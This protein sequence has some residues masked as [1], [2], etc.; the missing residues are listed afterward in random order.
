MVAF[1]EEHEAFRKTV[2]T[3]VERE[4]DPYVDEWERDGTIPTHELF[5]KLGDLG[6]LGLEYDPAYGGRGADHLF[7]VVLGEEIGPRATPPAWPWRSPCRPTWPPRRCT[8]S[9]PRS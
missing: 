2:R 7:T 8:A 6:F 3:F 9:A 4:I 1:T 5:A